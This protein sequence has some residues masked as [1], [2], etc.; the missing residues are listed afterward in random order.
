MNFKRK[1]EIMKEAKRKRLADEK[2]VEK[3]KPIIEFIKKVRFENENKD[4]EKEVDQVISTQEMIDDSRER[5]K[6]KLKKF[7]CDHCDYNSPSKT[8]LKRHKEMVHKEKDDQINQSL[9]PQLLLQ[10]NEPIQ[11]LKLSCDQCEYKADTKPNLKM[12]VETQHQPLEA[13]RYSCEQ[14][15]Y[16]AFTKP[17]LKTHEE[18]DH[19]QKKAEKKVAKKSSKRKNCDLCGKKFN[20]EETYMNHM[21][22]D[23]GQLQNN[24]LNQNNT[25]STLTS[26][27]ILRSNKKKSSTLDHII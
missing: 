3:E 22:K 7:A 12:H 14:C 9:Q 25:I 27:R 19:H 21:K 6:M 24:E 4:Q 20:K 13:V 16:K 2:S 26:Q 1:K 5:R 11:E 8:M 18:T 23:H 17:N 15:D 10:L